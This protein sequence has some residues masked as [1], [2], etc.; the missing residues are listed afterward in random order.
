MD[1]RLVQAIRR[2]AEDAA[3]AVPRPRWGIVASVNPAGPFIRVLLQPEN[4]LTG[5]LPAPQQMA[6]NGWGMVWLPLPGAKAFLV[7]EMDSGDDYVVIGYGYNDGQRPPAAAGGELV[8][9][10]ATG[11]V[12]TLLADGSF[13]A[14]SAA[15]AG[16]SLPADG[17]VWMQ[18]KSGGALALNGDGTGTISATS[19]KIDGPL[20]VTGTVTAP[21]YVTASVTVGSIAAPTGFA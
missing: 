9:K 6:D 18:D 1:H 13:N 11:T 4:V 19:F 14:K 16:L 5:W 8:L 3:N 20:F 2:I 10:H 21:N 7:P 12:V 15:G 17:R